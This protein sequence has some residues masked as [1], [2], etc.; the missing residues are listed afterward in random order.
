MAA[1]ERAALSLAGN[2]RQHN[3]DIGVVRLARIRGR[4]VDHAGEPLAGIPITHRTA[5]LGRVLTSDDTAPAGQATSA[6]DGVFTL[7][8]PPGELTLIAHPPDRPEATTTL[9]WVPP[10]SQLSGVEIVVDQGVSVAGTVVDPAG[11]AGGRRRGGR[12]RRRSNASD[13]HANR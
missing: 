7:Q 2:I 10:G 9:R 1:F 11:R 5:L 4:V 3:L 8:V 13:R 6:A 12:A